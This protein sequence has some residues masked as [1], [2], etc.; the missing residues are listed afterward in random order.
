MTMAQSAESAQPPSVPVGPEAG[1]VASK[2]GDAMRD[3][4]VELGF[5]T[6]DIRVVKQAR[7]EEIDGMH[8]F[9][10]LPIW[11]CGKARSITMAELR[12]PPHLRGDRE[13]TLEEIRHWANRIEVF[14]IDYWGGTPAAIAD[15]DAELAEIAREDAEALE[16]AEAYGDAR[17]G[18]SL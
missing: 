12:L 11:L 9:G 17:L 5:C 10:S 1:I 14:T 8:V 2:H 16:R 3:Y 6:P 4:F 7:R 13:L 15:I 18:Q